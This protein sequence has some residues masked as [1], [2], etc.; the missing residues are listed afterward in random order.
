MKEV[1]LV[2]N[3]ELALKGHNRS[4]FEDVLINNI[5]RRLNGLGEFSYSKAQSTILIEPKNEN[6]DLNEAEQVIS[7]VFGIAAYSRA[8]ALPKNMDVILEKTPEYLSKRLEL[9]STFKVE[10]KRSDKK[11]SLTS[12]EISALLGG[13]ILSVFGHLSVD[14]HNPDITVTAE[15]RDRY[16]LVRGTQLKGA[17]GLPTGT[18][19][20]SALLISGGIDSPVA[21]YMMA[22]RGMELVCIHFAS[23]P[24]TSKR[25]EQK[26]HSLLMKIAAFCGNIKLYVVPFTEIQEQIRINCPE[27]YHTLITRRFMMRIAQK[28]AGDNGC[29]ALV[30]GESLGQVASQ[31]LQAISVIDA[32]AEMPVFRPLIGMDKEEIIRISRKI[33]TFDIS[34]LPFEDCCTV[35]TPRHPRTRPKLHS[36]EKSEL[37]LFV[38]SLCENAVSNARTVYI[39]QGTVSENGYEH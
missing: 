4:S 8:A 19:G 20:K 6:T 33:D 10:A 22:K 28:I 38:P 26:V 34:V 21:G 11:F 17:G 29:E 36:A 39:G 2:K 16:A 35:F 12:P 3:G 37:A 25:A 31:T 9:S 18:A 7:K 32:V 13:K 27:D 23:P 1:I 30:T 14:V 24:Y 5:R 15:I